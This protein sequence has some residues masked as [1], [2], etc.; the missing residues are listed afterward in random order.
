MKTRGHFVLVFRKEAGADK[1]QHSYVVVFLGVEELSQP[2]ENLRNWSKNQM[3]CNVKFCR[4][5]DLKADDL[6]REVKN[7]DQEDIV[8]QIRGQRDRFAQDEGD[9][10]TLKCYVQLEVVYGQH[11]F[12]ADLHIKTAQ[13]SP[14][15]D[16]EQKGR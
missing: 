3:W 8:A 1:T 6:D 12:C 5:W 7:S 14:H 13:V 10:V 4:A 15:N 9:G 16:I 11:L 2:A